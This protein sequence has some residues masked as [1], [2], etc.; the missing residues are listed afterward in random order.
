MTQTNAHPFSYLTPELIIQAVEDL[1]YLSD[2]RL[3]ALNSYENRV[4]RIGIEDQAPLIT[5]FYRPQRW[6]DEQIL[7]EHAFCY[8]LAEQELSV[9]A[10]IKL[11]GKSL[12]TIEH[13]GI[14]FRYALFPTQ[15]GHAPELDND[16]NLI[17]LGR[18]LGRLHTLGQHSAF[19]HRPAIT[20]DDYAINS[21]KLISDNFMPL[22]LKTAYSSLSEDILK[23]LQSLDKHRAVR[24][25][26]DCHIGNILWRDNTAH[27]V[28]FDD[29]RMAPAIQDIWM[30]LSGEQ[31]QQRIQLH[32]LLEGYEEFCEFNT[33]EL[34]LIETLRT[35]RLMHHAAWLAKRWQDPAF[36]IAFPWFNSQRYWENHILE[37]REQLSLLQ[38][39][40]LSLFPN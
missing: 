40:P 35:L 14:L 28:D 9:V 22:E 26:A 19:E 16:D 38:S 12:F 33:Q 25:H 1:G 3:L 34:P 21:I 15:G 11:N 2:A 13:E 32:T 39:E 4:Y 20:I 27:F 17:V 23:N 31:N 24:C 37:L 29:C 5:K 8:Q 36:P 10:P 6:S 18:F 7:E 30:F